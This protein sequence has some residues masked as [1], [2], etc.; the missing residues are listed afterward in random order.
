MSKLVMGLGVFIILASLWVLVFP[1]QL[2]SLTDWE[3]REM[4]YVA[5]GMRVVIGL[6]LVL[7]ASSTRSPTGIRVVGGL[8]VLAGIGLLF[9]PID[10]WR[11]LIQYWLVDNLAMYRFG[12][13]AFG[14]LI[15][16]FFV[17]AS[18]PKTPSA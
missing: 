14:I 5:A 18:S 12:G 15:G 1:E 10:L 3:S 4:L 13:G 2:V 6:V 9:I 16:A 7:S 17:H 8:T 11:D